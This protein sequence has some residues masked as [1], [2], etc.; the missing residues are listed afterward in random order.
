VSTLLILHVNGNSYGDGPIF[1][2][3]TQGVFDASDHVA[4]EPFD[5]AAFRLQDLF[6]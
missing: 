3:H 1:G 6:D 2:P 4:V 5:S